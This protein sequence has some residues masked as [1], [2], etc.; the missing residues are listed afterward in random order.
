MT[1]GE[2]REQILAEHAKLRRMLADLEECSKSALG[3][4]PAGRE[5]LRTMGEQLLFDLEQHMQHE[6]RHLI[7]ALRTIDSWGA[8]RAARV[9]AD[10]RGQREQMRA[11]LDALR[12]QNASEADLA[13]LL[14]DISTWLARDMAEEEE[15]TLHPDVLRDDVVGIEVDTG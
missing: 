1:P 2:L 13:A 9:E 6:D 3:R 10:H 12:Q 7:P 4:G 5:E 11:Y 14:L 8:E 15:T